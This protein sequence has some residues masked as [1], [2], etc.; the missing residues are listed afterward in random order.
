MTKSTAKKAPAKKAA[1]KKAAASEPMDPAIHEETVAPMVTNHERVCYAARTLA[2]EVEALF[3]ET[4]VE[5]SNV[6]GRNT[7]LDVTFDLTVLDEADRDDLTRVLN[8]VDSDP[9]VDL[10]IAGGAEHEGQVLV[11]F[12]S[13]LRTQDSREP[14][15]LAD[16]F[17]V[18]IDSDEMGGSL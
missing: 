5:Y 18:L 7:A 10:V 15:G 11:S 2:S 14:F 6:D 16:A 9:R 8:L 13:S 17:S 4:P 12:K 3:P 1:A